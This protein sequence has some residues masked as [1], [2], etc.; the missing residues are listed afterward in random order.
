M[1]VFDIYCLNQ[2]QRLID[3]VYQDPTLA[4]EALL[5]PADYQR[6]VKDGSEGLK[7]NE[8]LNA[9]GFSIIGLLVTERWY[10]SERT[11]GQ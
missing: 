1:D 10:P 4:W 5:I 11:T 7:L 8:R 6:A 3:Y 2:L 9:V